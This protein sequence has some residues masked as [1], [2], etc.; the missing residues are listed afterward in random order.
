MKMDYDFHY[1]ATKA[2]AL[3][4]GF[5]EESAEAIAEAAIFT[6]YCDW[7]NFGYEIDTQ[8]KEYTVYTSQFISYFSDSW[9]PDASIWSAYH[10]VPGNYEH[11]RGHK[12]F[13]KRDGNVANIETLCRPYSAIA[14]NIIEDT[15][16]VLDSYQLKKEAACALI[17]LRM[18]VYADTW[19]H[20]D[21]SGIKDFNLS[22][23]LSEFL[24]EKEKG[25]YVALKRTTP[26]GLKNPMGDLACASNAMVGLGHG[27]AGHLPDMDWLNFKYKP[28]WMNGGYARNY[29][30]D[31][32]KGGVLIR[33]NTK[34]YEQAFCELVRAMHYLQTGKW[35]ECKFSEDKFLQARI[36]SKIAIPKSIISMIQTMRHMS[37]DKAVCFKEAAI[38]WE[39]YFKACKVDVKELTKDSKWEEKLVQKYKKDLYDIKYTGIDTRYQSAKIKAGS[40]F[41]WFQRAA[42]HHLQ[43]IQEQ[44]KDVTVL[45]ESHKQ[46]TQGWMYKHS[47]GVNKE[48]E[49]YAKN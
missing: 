37:P 45:K 2:A 48:K 19:A 18:H 7:A 15:K 17:G 20:Q 40:G 31:F 25:K 30:G 39:S 24:Y 5:E 41:Y 23:V 47:V 32:K 49:I 21:F 4:S 29:D 38:A 6:D 3:L 28:A 13:V 46:I 33:E 27:A 35:L 16:K 12:S 34:E 10:F 1:Y 43:F 22:A 44:V 26:Q 42:K 9:T 11:E 14:C 36:K 8:K